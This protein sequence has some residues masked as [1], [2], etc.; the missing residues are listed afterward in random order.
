M[1][2]GAHVLIGL[3]QAGWV[4]TGGQQ[5]LIRLALDAQE[6][7]S[8]EFGILEVITAS[9]IARKAAET[10]PRGLHTVVLSSGLCTSTPSLWNTVL[11]TKQCDP[12]VLGWLVRELTPAR[13]RAIIARFDWDT[14]SP[15]GIFA[16]R[17]DVLVA[18]LTQ[19]HPAPNQ[20]PKALAELRTLV[21]P[22]VAKILLYDDRDVRILGTQ[23]L[24]RF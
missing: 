20:S 8:T 21:T 14:S 4:P 5:R 3:C 24:G 23:V 19:M 6:E 7:N 12:G 10:S 17:A 13:A 9:D 18:V 2:P 22:L 1:G 11:E 16:D 15:T